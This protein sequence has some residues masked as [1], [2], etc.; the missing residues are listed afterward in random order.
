MSNLKI[1]ELRM[2]ARGRNTDGYQKMFR[3]LLE[4]L[5]ITPPVH[6]PI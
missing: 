4:S 3:E 5:F 2:F 6:A 1:D